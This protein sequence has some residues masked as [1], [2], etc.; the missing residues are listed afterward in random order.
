[1]T[2]AISPSASPR[3][4]LGCAPRRDEV[5][6]LDLSQR[7]LDEEQVRSADLI[8][9]YLPM[10]TATRIA[11]SAIKKVRALNPS[12]QLCAYGLYAPLNAAHLRAAG[13]GAIFGGE[14]EP[15]LAA[16]ARAIAGNGR[17]LPPQAQPEISLERLQFRV[18]D[19]TG[20]PPL[21]NYAR[22]VMPN[23]ALRTVGYTEAS[24]GCK[25]LCR[26]CPIVPV[27]DGK[28]RV[29]QRDVVLRTFAVRSPPARAHHLRRSGLLQRV[30]PRLE[31]VRALHR[32][33][34]RISY[35]VTI[36]VEHLLQHAELFPCC[37]TPGAPS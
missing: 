3:R 8:A 12:A 22:L 23:G 21:Q 15:G 33:F 34:P 7:D 10:H 1:M 25:H 35:D 30:D 29:V 20:L 27:Y 32:E 2:S 6:C 5:C 13:V 28:F 31:L 36:K 9:F 24:R 37:A 14:F 18:P 4:R 11:L 19:R 16:A 17:R 26:H